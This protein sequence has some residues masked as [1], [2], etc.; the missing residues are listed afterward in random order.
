MAKERRVTLCRMS[1]RLGA[2]EPESCDAGERS[3][4]N[5]LN[6]QLREDLNRVRSEVSYLRRENEQLRH[7][8]L[9]CISKSTP[10]NLT[11]HSHN[12]T[13]KRDNSTF[14]H[15]STSIRTHLVRS[16]GLDAIESMRDATLAHWNK[17][18][19]VFCILALTHLVTGTL[20]SLYFI[21]KEERSE[22]RRR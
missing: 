12:I 5:L 21:T 20:L 3:E 7:L 13:Y 2:G 14:L 9:I 16:N 4:M 15:N 22:N 8:L 6:Q 17:I 19:V 18:T 1:E 10:P 11:D